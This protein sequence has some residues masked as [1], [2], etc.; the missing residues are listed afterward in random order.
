[1]QVYILSGVTNGPRKV[2]V[3]WSGATWNTAI[4]ISEFYNILT[5][6][7]PVDQYN[8]AI[9]NGT[10]IN[11]GTLPALSNSGDLIYMVGFQDSTNAG[12]SGSN[13]SYFT[14]GS[15]FALVPGSTNSWDGSYAQYR[16][17]NSQTSFIPGITVNNA[18]NYLSAVVALKPASAGTA[19]ASGIRVVAVQHV[20][21]GE[22]TGT[23]ST[24][25]VTQGNLQIFMGTGG[26]LSDAITST[27]ANAQ[28]WAT[29][30][31][32]QDTSGPGEPD[33]AFYAV[34]AD[35]CNVLPG[36]QVLTIPM[37]VTPGQDYMLLDVTGAAAAPYDTSSGTTGYQGSPGNLTTIS[38]FSPSTSHGL[39]VTCGCQNMLTSMDLVGSGQYS[40]TATVDDNLTTCSASDENNQYGMYY[41]PDTS[42]VTFTWTQYG[43]S[44][45]T[46]VKDW[47]TSAVSY[48]AAAEVP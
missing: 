29:R 9:V 25:F 34:I 12:N 47:A 8:T 13:Y 45:Q 35:S 41:N 10:G 46:I 39:I 28:S 6:S 38:G 16:Q 11:A 33:A 19:P 7:S 5:T 40:L 18:Q 23:M 32:T 15:G 21:G 44:S 26:P 14:P 36:S 20:Y 3:T 37:T 43:T 48:K 31:Q 22:S 24:Q 17:Y 30:I 27:G 4:K 42:A 1:L 2:T